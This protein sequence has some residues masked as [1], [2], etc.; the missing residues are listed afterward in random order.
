MTYRDPTLQAENDR[1]RE[2]NE[3]LVEAL[4][5]SR[6]A[7]KPKSRETAAERTVTVYAMWGGALFGAGFGFFAVVFGNHYWAVSW[8]ALGALLCIGVVRFNRWALRTGE[9]S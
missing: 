4:A 2:E 5:F 7:P 8:P 6:P 9:P 3:R 1:L